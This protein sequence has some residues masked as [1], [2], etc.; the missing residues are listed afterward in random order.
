MG[1]AK[2]NREELR[3]RMIVELERL[4]EPTSPEEDRLNDEIR[5]LNF[6]SISRA[7]HDMIAYMR[8]VPQQCHQ[9]AGVY[10]RLDPSGESKHISGWWKRNGIFYFHSVILNQGKMHCITPHSDRLPLEFAPDFEIAWTEADGKMNATRRGQLVPF[11]VRDFPEKV[12]AEATAARDALVAGADP[13]TIE[14]AL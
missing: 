3:K 7:P 4:M 9:N 14:V 6:Y 11:L 13:R 10:A 1:E 12:I 2:R 8:M 5:A